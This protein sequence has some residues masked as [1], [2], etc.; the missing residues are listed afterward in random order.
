ML[1]FG[2][3]ALSRSSSGRAVGAATLAVGA[4]KFLVLTPGILSGVE[5]LEHLAIGIWMLLFAVLGPAAR[6]SNERRPPVTAH[7]FAVRN[8]GAS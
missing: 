3:G 1:L 8:S 7:P 4:A 2:I 5:A 6:R